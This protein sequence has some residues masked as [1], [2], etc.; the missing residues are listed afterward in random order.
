[1]ERRVVGQQ[2]TSD[3]ALLAIARQQISDLRAVEKE[4]RSAY[5]AKVDELQR[6]IH[7]LRAEE[8]RKIRRVQRKFKPAGQYPGVSDMEVSILHNVVRDSHLLDFVKSGHHQE[9]LRKWADKRVRYFTSNYDVR[10]A[11]HFR[12][13]LALSGD[14]PT[15]EVPAQE[16]DG[17]QADPPHAPER[18]KR[19]PAAGAPRRQPKTGAPSRTRTRAHPGDPSQQE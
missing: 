2:Q 18:R 16:D 9:A 11:N 14:G 4:I 6:Q 17:H 7:A 10:Q 15:T 19:K 13:L 1:M 5:N 3:V 8:S 12:R